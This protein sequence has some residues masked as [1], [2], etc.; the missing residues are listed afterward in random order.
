MNDCCKPPKMLHECKKGREHCWH[1]EKKGK[2]YWDCCA[3]HGI[4]ADIGIGNKFMELLGRIAHWILPQRHS[5]ILKC[6]WCF[7]TL[8]NDAD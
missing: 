7:E 3:K 2:S 6:C 4:W 1:L 8:E 5:T